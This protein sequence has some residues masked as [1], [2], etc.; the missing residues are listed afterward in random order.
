[1]RFV[2]LICTEM[3]DD[4]GGGLAPAVS[5]SR[6]GVTTEVV[7]CSFGVLCREGSTNKGLKLEEV[8][9]RADDLS[10]DLLD[11]ESDAVGSLL[12]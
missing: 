5:R 6:C 10:L 2:P 11:G 9:L 3:E 4:T 12:F 1:M 8:T 7:A